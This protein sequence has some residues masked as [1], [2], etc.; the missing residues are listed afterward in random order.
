MITILLILSA[1]AAHGVSFVPAR[2]GAR[3]HAGRSHAHRMGASANSGDAASA[4][5]STRTTPPPATAA[6]T[7]ALVEA[8]AAE[9]R[10]KAS[11]RQTQYWIGIAGGPGT[12]K[13]T[14]AH[15]LCTAL[16][17]DLAIV[18]PMDGFHYTKAELDVFPDPT[19]A[20]ARR[21][22][23]FTF[24]A[25]KFA[26][27]LG[28]LHA[29]GDGTWPSFDHAV[30]DPV[31]DDLVLEQKHRIVIV[32][33]N[34]LLLDEPF[35]REARQHFDETLFVLVEETVARDRV[36]TRNAKA[37]GWPLECAYARVDTNDLINMRLIAAT[38]QFATRVINGDDI[39]LF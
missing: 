29:A 6:K 12:G 10:F 25:T 27:R 4:A 13:T 38:E 8:L 31:D 3:G 19:L 7:C 23:P 15:A 2:L 5:S 32:E 18:L 14:L 26:V 37:W 21:G 28:A 20:Y 16:G 33:G 34:Y 24:N 30:G 35:W 1:C 11:E 36:A 39:K 17:S 22:A 9:L